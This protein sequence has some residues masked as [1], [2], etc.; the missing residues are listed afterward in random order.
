MAKGEQEQHDVD[1]GEGKG[2]GWGSVGIVLAQHNEAPGSI[3]ALYQPGV[4]GACL[5]SQQSDE[6]RKLIMSKVQ[7]HLSHIEFEDQPREYDTSCLKNKQ[8]NKQI[9]K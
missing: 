9:I 4:V 1:K 6:G 5:K 3:P 2:W 7:G 8:T